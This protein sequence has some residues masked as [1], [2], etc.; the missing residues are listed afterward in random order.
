[1][2]WAVCSEV[3]PTSLVILVLRRELTRVRI[4]RPVWSAP[5]QDVPIVPKRAQRIGEEW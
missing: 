5:T 3:C 1:M 4:G 2:G